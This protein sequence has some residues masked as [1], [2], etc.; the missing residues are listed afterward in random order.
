MREFWLAGDEINLSPD[1]A[2]I[3]SPV[4][5]KKLTA[6]CVLNRLSRQTTTFS[7]EYVYQIS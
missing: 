2:S 6:K 3:Y 4:R 7:G 5:K 1:R